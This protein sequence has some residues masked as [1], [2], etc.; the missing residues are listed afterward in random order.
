MPDLPD[1]PV[2]QDLPD[3]PGEPLLALATDG[4]VRL[5]P[6][7][8]G[9]AGAQVAGE[10]DAMIRWLSGGRSTLAGQRRSLR[11]T[12]A[13]WDRRDPVFDLGVELVG[14]GALVGTLRLHAGLD[15]LRP[16]E[17]NVSYGLYPP[18]RGRGLASRALALGIGVAID[19]FRPSRW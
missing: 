12:R 10:D 1:L 4:V 14:S 9:D 18:W 6:L 7:D 15:V 8:V 13:A 17:V 16:G 3:T 11:R 2:V 5:R 19:R